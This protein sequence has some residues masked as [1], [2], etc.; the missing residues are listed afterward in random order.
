MTAAPPTT[1]VLSIRDLSVSFRT[2]AG[3]VPAVLGVSID[4]SLI[5]SRAGLA[6]KARGP[7][8]APSMARPLSVSASPSSTSGVSA[9]TPSL[10]RMCSTVAIRVLAPSSRMSRSTWSTR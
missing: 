10:R 2:A 9:S 3:L 6:V 7:R 5:V 8:G 4:D 1:P